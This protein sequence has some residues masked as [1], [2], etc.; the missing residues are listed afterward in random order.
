MWHAKAEALRDGLQRAERVL[1]GSSCSSGGSPTRRLM[2][3]HNRNVMNM[4]LLP[5]S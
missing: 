2:L 5:T 4:V 1:V 3:E